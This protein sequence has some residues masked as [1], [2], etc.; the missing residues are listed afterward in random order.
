MVTKLYKSTHGIIHM[1]KTGHM[2]CNPET[3]LVR[4]Y[5]PFGVF[6]GSQKKINC[7]H[8]KKRMKK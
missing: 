7:K 3:G 8:C 4:T 5:N 1:M 2:L 6:F